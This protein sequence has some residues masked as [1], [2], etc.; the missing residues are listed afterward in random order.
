[1][2]HIGKSFRRRVRLDGNTYTDCKFRNAEL[3]FRGGSPPTFVNCEF[4]RVTFGFDGAA[5]NTILMLKRMAAPGAGLDGFV[6]NT[7]P[8]LQR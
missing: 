5:A 1:M 8:E 7:L 2:N 6:R 4:Y 3:V